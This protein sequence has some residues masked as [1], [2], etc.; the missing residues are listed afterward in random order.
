MKWKEVSGGDVRYDDARGIERQSL[1]NN[2]QISNDGSECW[3][4]KMRTN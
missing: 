3:P 1:Q 4:L 2:H